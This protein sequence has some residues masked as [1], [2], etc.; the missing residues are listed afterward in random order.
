[1]SFNKIQADIKAGKF[2]PVYLFMGEEPFFIDQLSSL[3]EKNALSEDLKGFNQTILYGSD[4]SVEQIVS[5]ARSFPMMGDRQVLII[6]EAQS[7]EKKIQDLKVYCAQPSETTI[8][9]INYKQ[10]KLDKRTELYKL[11]EKNGVVFNSETIRD[12]K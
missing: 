11:I 9:V 7:L 6:K 10:K 4:T 8:L 2:A 12:Y 3:I 1:M 5:S